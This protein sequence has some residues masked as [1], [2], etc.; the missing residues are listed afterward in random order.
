MLHHSNSNSLIPVLSLQV[1]DDTRKWWKTRNRRGHVAHVPHTI[2][3]PF[4]SV[5]DSCEVFNSPL[6]GRGHDPGNRGYVGKVSYERKTGC[7]FLRSKVKHEFF[8]LAALH[9]SDAS[10][11]YSN[12]GRYYSLKIRTIIISSKK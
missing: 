7:R 8:L 11:S 5:A 4:N 2:V 1:L 3:M 10:H 12:T 6:Y 9:L